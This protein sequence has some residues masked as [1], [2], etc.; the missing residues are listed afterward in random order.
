MKAPLFVRTVSPDEQAKISDG[1]RSCDAFTFRRC[2]ILL[3]SGRGQRPSSIARNLGCATQTVRNA[4]HAFD[5]IGQDCLKPESSRPKTVQA[6]FDQDVCEELRAILHKPPR[7][8]NKTTSLWTL[9][10]ASEVCLEQGLTEQQVSI[11]T[12]RQA[13]KRLG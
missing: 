6:Q 5:E 8:F 10:L 3:A 11:E 12:I 2:Q 4:I 9:Q 1:L 7:V 13:L